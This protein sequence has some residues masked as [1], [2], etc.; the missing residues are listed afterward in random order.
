MT[1][2]S[3]VES[4]IKTTS[5]PAFI[6]K[7]TRR[8]ADRGREHDELRRIL[9]EHAER[10]GSTRATELLAIGN[11]RRNRF[12]LITAAEN[13]RSGLRTKSETAGRRERRVA[14]P[15]AGEVLVEVTGRCVTRRVHAERRR[16]RGLVPG[17]SS[18]TKAQASSREIGAESRRRARDH[19]VLL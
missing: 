18:A 6:R 14:S 4:T 2:G 12:A 17:R 1:G 10:S 8:R 9:A 3:V 5:A 15:K 16:S 19:V 13:D 11:A 7:R